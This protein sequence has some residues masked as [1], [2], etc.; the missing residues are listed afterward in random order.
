MY[1]ISLDN[2]SSAHIR[3]SECIKLSGLYVATL[4][5][6][7]CCHSVTRYLKVGEREKKLRFFFSHQPTNL[8]LLSGSTMKWH[9]ICVHFLSKYYKSFSFVLFF[10]G[11]CDP[12]YGASFQFEVHT[13]EL[14]VGEIFVRVYN[15]QPT[16]VLEVRLPPSLLILF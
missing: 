14:V 13:K 10:Q 9:W 1:K 3:N 6:K 12:D 8:S 16:F 4:T 5:F 11:E 2:F 7:Q 15:E